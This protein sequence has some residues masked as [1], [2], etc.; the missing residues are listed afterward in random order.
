MRRRSRRICRLRSNMR[1]RRN[2]RSTC[3]SLR[4]RGRRL[5][6]VQR[7]PAWLVGVGTAVV[8]LLLGAGIYYFLN[9]SDSSATTTASQDKTGAAATGDAAK[10]KV[11][12]PMQKYVEV[13]GIRMIDAE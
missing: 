10:G 6:P 2:I 8:F 5:N 7:P 1:H 4:Q 3:N 13:V 9:R 11:T 12:N